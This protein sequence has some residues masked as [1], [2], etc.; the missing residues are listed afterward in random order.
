MKIINKISSWVV[1]SL[2]LCL[3]SLSCR[4]QEYRLQTKAPAV[5][6]VLNNRKARTPE[7]QTL[8]TQGLIGENNRGFLTILKPAEIQAAEK[9]LMEA[10]NHDRKFIYNTVVA[11][12]HLESESLVKVEAEFAKTRHDRARKGDFIQIPSGKWI[13]K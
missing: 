7:I 9:S 1:L 4:E 11:Q 3:G 8:K 13:Q 6:K 12:N 10:E 5:Q 2:F